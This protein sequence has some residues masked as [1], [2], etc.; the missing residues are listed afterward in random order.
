MR[1]EWKVVGH[2]GFCARYPENTLPGFQAACKAGVDA[3]ELDVQLSA[4]GIPLVFHDEDLARTTDASGLLKEYRFDEL[5]GFSA[6]YPDKFGDKFSP[7]AIASL[8]QV[9]EALAGV[10][11]H[12]FIEIKKESIPVLG[13][14]RYV[15]AVLDASAAFGE[16][17][18]IISFDDEML[19]LSKQMS[20]LPVGLCFL[21]YT[22]E[23]RQLAMALKPD[24]MICEHAIVPREAT[25]WAGDWEWFFYGIETTEQAADFYQ[26]GV[27]WIEADDPLA[28]IVKPE[29]GMEYES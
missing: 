2:R 26:R 22:E 18:S 25:L 8:K 27:N 10:A 17:R 1:N 23:T 20:P 6:H 14:E 16:K 28:V 13:R 24:I 5:A 21:E 29:S 12:V 19:E 7:I 3:I 15:Q 4:D 11:P 9:A